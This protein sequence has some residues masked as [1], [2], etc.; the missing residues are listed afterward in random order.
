MA[1]WERRA[2]LNNYVVEKRYTSAQEHTEQ[3]AWLNIR[4][5]GL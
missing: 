3:H 4:S 1:Q 5:L 2:K